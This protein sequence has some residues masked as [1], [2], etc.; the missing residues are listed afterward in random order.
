MTPTLDT[1]HPSHLPLLLA[2]ELGHSP[3]EEAEPLDRLR[4]QKAVFILQMAGPEAWSDA[5]NFVAWDWGPFS[6]DLAN[7]LVV[8]QQQGLMETEPVQWRRYPR[9]KT[10]PEGEKIAQKVASELDEKHRAFIRKVRRYVTS[11]SFSQLLREVY[12]RF[13]EFAVN[14]RFQG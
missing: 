3:E 2:A 12:S 11:R 13:P 9:Y 7:E 5:F 6:R 1:M 8:L 10:T 14:S 4:M